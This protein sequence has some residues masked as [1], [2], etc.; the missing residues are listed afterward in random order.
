MTPHSEQVETPPTVDEL[1]MQHRDYERRL[2]EL[3]QRPWLSPE[4]EIEE[5]RLKKLKLHLKDQIALLQRSSV[6]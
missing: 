2:E 3:K 6:S 1:Q 4:E 5:K